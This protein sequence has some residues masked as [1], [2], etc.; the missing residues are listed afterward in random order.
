[1]EIWLKLLIVLIVLLIDLMS[2][3]SKATFCWRVLIRSGLHMLIANIWNVKSNQSIEKV[4][5]SCQFFNAN[6]LIIPNSSYYVFDY[7]S[8]FTIHLKECLAWCLIIC[9]DQFSFLLVFWNY[10]LFAGISLINFIRLSI[11]LTKRFFSP[12]VRHA[13]A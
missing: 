3:R 9:I 10:G 13:V 12:C 2:R 5:F 8:Y 4:S 6:V 7:A 1:M 11:L